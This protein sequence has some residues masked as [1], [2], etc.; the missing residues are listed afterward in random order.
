L[1]ETGQTLDRYRIESK[2]GEG[3]MG[4]VYKAHDSS[5]NRS[6][7]IK[8]LPRDK[9]ADPIRK[10]RFAQEAKAASA[11]NHPNIV[12]IHD[13]RSDHGIDFIV[14]ECIE[15]QTLGQLIS[16]KGMRSA[17]V[18][19]FAV[20]MADALS[21]AHA[22]GILHRDLKP[23]NVMVMDEG[24]VK[25]LDFGLAKLLE[26]EQS[27]SEEPTLTTLGS[28]LDGPV[29]G[30]P[31]YM[32]PEQAEGH[33]LDARS[34]IFSFGSVLYEMVTGR[35]P[36]IGDSPLSLLSIVNEE[37]SPP[38]QFGVS[39]PPEFERLILRC[40]RKNPDRRYQTMADLKV[41][42]EDLQ[43]ESPESSPGVLVQAT[44]R[45]RWVWAA[46]PLASLAAGLFVWQTWRVTNPAEPLRAIALTTLP[47]SELYPSLSP[48]GN[49]IV[50]AWTEPKQINSDIYVQTIGS[51][52]PL[53]LTTNPKTDYNPVWSPD[54]RWIA[55][56]RAEQSPPDANATVGKGELRL[57]PPLGGP[58]RKLADIWVRGV[59]GNPAFLTWCPDSTCLVITDTQGESKPD[60]LFVIAL[61]TGE[62]RQLTHPQLPLLGDSNPAVSPDGRSL[63]FRRA[64]AAGRGELHWLPLQADVIASGEPKRLTQASLDG[65]YR[66]ASLAA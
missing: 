29:V 50:F 30:T 64:A 21:K 45:R 6:V 49:Q 23:S 8:V 25:I 11:L 28:S 43:T 31:A 53:K 54:G 13:I 44:P 14:M 37:P 51:G 4:V 55:F 61:E 52:S 27:S 38:G 32:S 57:I 20:Q 59:I 15:G 65:A 62:K 41:A 42:L 39:I 66:A 34:D 26:P 2:L 3:G 7:A 33:K 17:Q 60:A 18:L 22:A 16:R 56:I 9:V 58:E 12:T 40:L 10:Q 46:L 48:D 47:G 63:V 24:R 1:L 35:K 19:S 36:F 5:L